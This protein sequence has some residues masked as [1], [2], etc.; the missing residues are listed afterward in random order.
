M[1]KSKLKDELA[2][3]QCG[4]FWQRKTDRLHEPCPF[5]G[6]IKDTRD[7]SEEAKS[8][9]RATERFEKLKIWYADKGNRQERE[10]RYRT[11]LRKQVFFRICGDI[12]PRCVRCGCDDP[13]LLEINHKNGGGGKEMDHGKNSQ[14]FY[15]AIAV[16]KR[17]T[18]DLEI[19]CKPCNAIH[20]L[21]MKYGALPLRVIWKG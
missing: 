20:A 4:A 19:L 16:G 2:C 5:C 14:S 15:H 9:E 17:T 7:R 13:R 18:E 3:R 12:V 1:A 21:E 11:K 10:A 8:Y 6:K